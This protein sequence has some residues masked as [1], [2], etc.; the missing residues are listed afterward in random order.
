[1]TDHSVL[2]K[3]FSDRVSPRFLKTNYADPIA[4]RH[5]EGEGPLILWLGGFRS[6]MKGGKIDALA[7]QA[8]ALGHG[9]LCFDYYAHGETGGDWD[10]ARIGRWLDNAL[11]VVDHLTTGPLVVIGSS[12][13]GWLA[14]LVQKHRPERVKSL[15]LVAPA[16]DFIDCLIKEKMTPEEALNLKRSGTHVMNSFDG[17]VHLSQAVFDEAVQH[18]VLTSPLML[19]GKVR[20]LHGLMDDVVPV[21]HVVRLFSHIQ[22]SDSRLLIIKD[23]DHRLSEPSDLEALKALVIDLRA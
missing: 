14:C 4:Y 23:A 13:G 11:S 2:T 6:D 10:K 16:A 3:N 17:P 21:D 9:F 1:M 19:S 20:I 5:I 22:S 18:N 15:G 12:M 8:E 7:T